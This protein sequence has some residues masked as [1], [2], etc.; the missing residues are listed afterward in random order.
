[1]SVHTHA[2]DGSLV[3]LACH[4]GS[5]ILGSTGPDRGLLSDFLLLF[6][7]VFLLLVMAAVGAQ[8]SCASDAELTFEQVAVMLSGVIGKPIPEIQA[9]GVV[10]MLH[11]AEV[12][13]MLKDTSVSIMTKDASS[14]RLR[15]RLAHGGA[16]RWPEAMNQLKDADMHVP[17]SLLGEGRLPLALIL[18]NNPSGRESEVVEPGGDDGD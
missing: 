14:W 15:A 13:G 7:V 6:S 17:E 10:D 5:R 3:G 1:M 4:F 2:G 16:V 9:A 18:W 11:A 8:T 12:M